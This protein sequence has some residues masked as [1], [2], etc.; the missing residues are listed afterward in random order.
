MNRHYFK[1]IAF[2]LLASLSTQAAAMNFFKNTATVEH[3]LMVELPCQINVGQTAEPLNKG[4]SASAWIDSF[5]GISAAANN[6][7]ANGVTLHY[8]R[9]QK[10]IPQIGF[11]AVGCIASICGIAV[12]THA[13]LQKDQNNTRNKYRTGAA[14]TA[15]GLVALGISSLFSK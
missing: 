3:E 8:G 5:N 10:I 15:F 14:M 6:L 9:A 7:V 12:L 11:C 13:A 2:V 1:K 4:A